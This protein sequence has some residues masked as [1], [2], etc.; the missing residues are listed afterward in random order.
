MR[1]NKLTIALATIAS[2]Q[3]LLGLVTQFFVIKT[4]GIGEK[5]DSVIWI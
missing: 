1:I 4:L 5:D 2:F 3:L